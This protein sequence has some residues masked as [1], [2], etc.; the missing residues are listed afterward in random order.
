M[1]DAG[2]RR[3][4][5]SAVAGVSRAASIAGIAAMALMVL[6]VTVDVA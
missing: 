5:R 6:H 4:L 1:T 3:W 2:A